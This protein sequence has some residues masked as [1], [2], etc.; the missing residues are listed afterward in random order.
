ML[1]ATKTKTSIG[2][3]MQTSSSFRFSSYE[4]GKQDQ[5]SRCCTNITNGSAKD[6][7]QSFDLFQHSGFQLLPK[8]LHIF[9]YF[10]AM[11]VFFRGVKFTSPFIISSLHTPFAMHQ[12]LRITLSPRQAEKTQRTICYQDCCCHLDHA[13]NIEK[14]PWTRDHGRHDGSHWHCYHRAG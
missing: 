14:H 4:E 5:D 10:Y 7:K 12:W 1:T 9:Q 2:A 6:F 13:Q 8:S 3:S 11:S